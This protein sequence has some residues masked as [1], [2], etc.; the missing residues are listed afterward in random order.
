MVSTLTT[1]TKES[2]EIVLFFFFLIDLR[3]K[4]S[5]RRGEAEGEADFPSARSLTWGSIPKP[6]D[7]DPS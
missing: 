3:E 7:H 5:T 6:G 2:A 4:E 1:E